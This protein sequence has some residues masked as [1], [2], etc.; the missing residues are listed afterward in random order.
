MIEKFKIKM[1][2]H[3]NW[4]LTNKIV[5][6]LTLSLWLRQGHKK[7]WAESAP[8]ESHSHI[9][10][11]ERVW[12]NEPTQSQVDSH[13]G[14]WNSYEVP[15][16]QKMILGVKTHWIEKFL[17]PLKNYWHIDVKNGFAWYIWVLRTQIMAK[18]KVENQKVNLILDH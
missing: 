3:Q 13:L 16:V 1:L 14:N 15:N 8:W 4:Q 2:L 18:R 9:W 10:E 11:C 5:M 7:V 12:R 17:I 6:T